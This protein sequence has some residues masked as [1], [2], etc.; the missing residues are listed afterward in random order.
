MFHL[1]IHMLTSPALFDAVKSVERTNK[2][3]NFLKITSVFEMS[4][5]AMD[6]DMMSHTFNI[7]Y[8]S[9]TRLPGAVP[10]PLF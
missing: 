6:L 4:S 8:I 3:I 2:L 1:D 10:Q 9:E 7:P 5:C